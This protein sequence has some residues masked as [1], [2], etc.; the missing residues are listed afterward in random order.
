[1]PDHSNSQGLRTWK[2]VLRCRSTDRPDLGEIS[3]LGLQQRV[4]TGVS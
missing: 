3:R 1:M 2:G 4:L